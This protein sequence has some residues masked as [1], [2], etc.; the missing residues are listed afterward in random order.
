MDANPTPGKA[1]RAAE[2]HSLPAPIIECSPLPMVEVEGANHVVCFV[3][4]AFCRLLSRKREELV[5]KPFDEI[6]SNAAS[7]VPLL[8]RVY[9]TGEFE[10]QVVPDPANPDPVNWVYAMWPALDEAARPER[11]IIQ[12]TKSAPFRRDAMAMNEA[13]LIGGLRQHELL[14]KS[15]KAERDLQVAQLELRAHADGLEQVITERTAQLRASM[16]EL[17][18]FSYSLVHDLRAPIRAIQGF[19]EMALDLPSEQMGPSA[20]EMLKRVV[21]AATRMDSLIQDVLSL[22]QVIRQPM[23][24][25]SVD[26]DALVRDL[27]KERPELASPRAEI[28]I[29]CTLVKMWGHEAT[30]SQCLTNLLSNA[31]KFVAPGVVPTVRVWSEERAAPANTEPKQTGSASPIPR[32]PRSAGELVRLFVEDNG[33]G[34]APDA[35]KTIFEIFQR[36]HTSSQYEGSG[37]GLA[38]V[39]KAINRMGGTVGIESVPGKGSRFWLELPK[40]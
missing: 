24:C 15:E 4:A 25:R 31:V 9:D 20:V 10:T 29:E 14:Q 19:T 11:V 39:R 17:E 27:V 35:H 12:M 38:I 3:N 5:G 2:E 22:T 40:G 28:K 16:E 33:I 7:C 13:L 6:V 8:N 18:A 32:S 26:L 37:I 34:I 36:L 23:N 30:L 21:K 1:D